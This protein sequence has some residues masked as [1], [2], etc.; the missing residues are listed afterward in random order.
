MSA[1]GYRAIPE[2]SA[3]RYGTPMS[4]THIVTFKWRDADYPGQPVAD[5]LSA[6]TNTLAGVQSYV[7]GPDIDLTPGSYDFAVVGIF[8]SREHFVAY[9]DHPEHQRI[10]A[11]LIAPQ[12]DVRTVVQLEN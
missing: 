12:L 4:F 8:D 10:I 1:C 11:E 7:C 6:L 2:V 5:A 9:R 3:P